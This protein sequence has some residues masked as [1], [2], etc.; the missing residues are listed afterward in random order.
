[1]SP[2]HPITLHSIHLLSFPVAF[3]NDPLVP[4]IKQKTLLKIQLKAKT[5]HLALTVEPPPLPK[6]KKIIIITSRII[7]KN[8]ITK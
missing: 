2:S 5:K 4:N 7:E 3:K 1:M 8:T 6:V